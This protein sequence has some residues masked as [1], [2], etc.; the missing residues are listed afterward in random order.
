MKPGAC[1]SI[2][3]RHTMRHSFATHLVD[4][5]VDIRRVQELLGH[6]DV[7]STT[8][9]VSA[10]QIAITCRLHGESKAAFRPSPTL[11]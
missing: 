1:Q 9:Q 3:H 5:G 2:A 11:V 10:K 4:S 8:C 7:S 6:S